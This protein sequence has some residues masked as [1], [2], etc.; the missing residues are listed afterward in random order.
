MKYGIGLSI[1]F[2]IGVIFSPNTNNLFEATQKNTEEQTL[3]I[4]NVNIINMDE[5]R[6]FEERDILISNDKILRIGKN[7]DVLN[8]AEIQDLK[9]RYIIPALFDMHAHISTENPWYRYHLSLFRYFGIHS[10]NFMAGSDELKS[11]KKQVENNNN[12][13]PKIYLASELID[14]DPPLWGEDHNGP[15]ITD[16]ENVEESLKELKDKGYSEIKVYNQL[17]E[18]VYLEILDLAED[19]DLR[20]VGHIPYSLSINSRLDPRHKRIEHLDGY[21]ELAYKGDR[22][23][24]Q[25]PKFQRTTLLTDGF[26]KD[27]MTEAARKTAERDI[28]NCPTHVLFSSLTDSSYINEVMEGDIF[29]LLDPTLERFWNNVVQNKDQMP[30]LRSENYRDVH[31]EMIGSLHEEGAKILAGTD[32]PQPILLYGH[33]LHK[34]LQYFVEA[35]MTPFEAIETATVNPVEFLGLENQGKIKEGYKAELI[36]L[37]DNPLMDIKNTLSIEGYISESSY[38]DRQEMRGLI[39]SIKDQVN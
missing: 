2:A 14:G 10:V 7:L 15:V 16:P 17:Q 30:H 29:N 36:I 21:L 13:S 35:G 6:V 5:D 37:G 23:V 11:L 8:G 27:K 1:L 18:D 33:A 4:Q 3:I 24:L 38:M 28:W 22:D 20:V 19:L 31:L 9:G 26:D 25:T 34:E 32:A 12:V 39:T